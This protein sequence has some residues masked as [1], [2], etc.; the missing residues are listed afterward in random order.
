MTDQDRVILERMERLFSELSKDNWRRDVRMEV[1]NRRIA[2]IGI[3]ILGCGC[4]AIVIGIGYAINR[5]SDTLEIVGWVGLGVILAAGVHSTSKAFLQDPLNEFDRR[6]LN[7]QRVAEGLDPIREP[8]L[9]E[10]IGGLF[11]IYVISGLFL[12]IIGGICAVIIDLLFLSKALGH[13]AQLG[14]AAFVV[15][16]V[17]LGFLLSV[18]DWLNN[19]KSKRKAARDVRRSARSG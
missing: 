10:T 4:W 17:G 8:T 13:I 16:F 5:T 18:S 9:V 15:G 12:A 11:L 3:W 7:A 6:E 2:S 19:W 14:L 1:I